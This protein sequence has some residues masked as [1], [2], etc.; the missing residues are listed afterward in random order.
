VQILGGSISERADSPVERVWTVHIDGEPFW[1]AYD[2]FPVG[3][4]LAPK[5][6]G[7]SALI[8]RIRQTLV[9]HRVSAD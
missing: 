6:I 1:L 5:S 8:A 7:A 4:C 2:D 9:D 3:V